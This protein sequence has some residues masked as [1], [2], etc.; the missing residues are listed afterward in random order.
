MGN[1][2][3]S[4]FILAK[5]KGRYQGVA[6]KSRINLKKSISKALKL[7]ALPRWAKHSSASFVVTLIENRTTILC[8]ASLESGRVMLRRINA[9]VVEVPNV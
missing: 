6:M 1:S 4:A 2:T 5:P 7:S 8:E 3:T 9:E